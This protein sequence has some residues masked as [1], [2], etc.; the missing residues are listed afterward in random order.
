ME[1]V[2]GMLYRVDCALCQPFITDNEL[3]AR[4]MYWIVLEISNQC[5]FTVI[6]KRMEA[7][8]I[9]KQARKSLYNR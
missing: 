7:R 4:R 1:G 2:D 5:S 3:E 9:L 8:T 6:P